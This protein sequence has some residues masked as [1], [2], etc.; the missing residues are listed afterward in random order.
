MIF[1]FENPSRQTQP[2][3]YFLLYDVVADF[4]FK[5]I[6]SEAQTYPYYM[7][8][9]TRTSNPNRIWL[10]RTSGWLSAIAHEFDNDEVKRQIGYVVGKPLVGARTRAELCMDSVGSWLEPHSDDAAKLLTLQLFLDGQ[11]WST[12]MGAETHSQVQ[13]MPNRAWLF[14]NGDQPVH[15]LPRLKHNRASIIINYVIEDEWK[16]KSV[17]V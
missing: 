5:R 16:D 6:Q 1:N 4:V 13:T 11:G 9:Q 7:I 8:E 12:A 2:F 3:E 15:K 10:N 17:L 14:Y